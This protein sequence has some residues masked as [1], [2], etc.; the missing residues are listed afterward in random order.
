M[1]LSILNWYNNFDSTE[2]HP[3]IHSYDTTYDKIFANLSPESISTK[4][5]IL[6]PSFQCETDSGNSSRCFPF[7]YNSG[8]LYY[9]KFCTIRWDN[10]NDNNRTESLDLLI[11][12][13]RMNTIWLENPWR[14]CYTKTSPF[15]ALIYR[16]SLP[17]VS[18]S[19]L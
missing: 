12:T 5:S 7:Q 15:P 3:R 2:Q 11:Y 4:C 6:A 9:T 8:C 1:I 16:T 18:W 17:E 10:T 19:S 14:F 13:P